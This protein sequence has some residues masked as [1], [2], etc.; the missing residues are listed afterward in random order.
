MSGVVFRMYRAM[1]V[2]GTTH[3]QTPI[4]HTSVEKHAGA[5]AYCLRNPENKEAQA[6]KLSMS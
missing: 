1:I 2:M 6:E 4:S 3:E 5:T